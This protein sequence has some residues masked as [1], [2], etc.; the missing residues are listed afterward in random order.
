MGYGLDP[1]ITIMITFS[2]SC[3]A[4]FDFVGCCTVAQSSCPDLMTDSECTPPPLKRKPRPSH[5]DD[6]WIMIFIVISRWVWSALVGGCGLPLIF[7]S[8]SWKL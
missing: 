6:S 2:S 7:V 4:I 1:Q 5:F 8:E 3:L